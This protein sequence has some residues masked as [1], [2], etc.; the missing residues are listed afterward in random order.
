[1]RGAS[2]EEAWREEKRR[3]GA[4]IAEA[5]IGETWIG[6]TWVGETWV[7]EAWIAP[8]P[9]PGA[10][11]SMDVDKA[12]RG[13]GPARGLREP[14]TPPSTARHEGARGVAV[15]GESGTRIGAPARSAAQ[16]A[17]ETVLSPT[18]DRIC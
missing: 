7:E 13:G 11:E 12:A 17:G 16:A 6:E 10:G 9:P 5:W 15:L 14:S 8:C 2:I 3:D 4:G 18:L 1:M